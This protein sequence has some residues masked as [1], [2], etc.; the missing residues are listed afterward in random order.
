[1]ILKFIFFINFCL[2]FCHYL[3]LQGYELPNYVQ[4]SIPEPI[5]PLPP[6]I[7]VGTSI[8]PQSNLYRCHNCPSRPALPTMIP[9]PEIV[10]L[11]NRNPIPSQL[12]KNFF[13]EVAFLKNI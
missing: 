9:T 11:P 7:P 12:G 8:Y 4:N 5:Y 3:Q 6:S 13:K 1:M 2:I 10:T